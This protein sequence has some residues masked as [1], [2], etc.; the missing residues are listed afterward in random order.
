MWHSR[1]NPSS[2]VEAEVVRKSISEKNK[3]SAEAVAWSKANM[4][5][6]TKNRTMSAYQGWRNH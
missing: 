2:K 6:S 5:G 3:Q 1:G 4:P